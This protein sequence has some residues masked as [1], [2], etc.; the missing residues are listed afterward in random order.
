MNAEDKTG[1]DRF[2]IR[3]YGI[4]EWEQKIL[5]I[6]ERI[7]DFRFTKF[8]GGGLE[9]GEGLHDGL[10]REFMEEAG[11]GIKVQSHFYT[12]HFF[13]QSMFRTSDQLIAVYYRVD[14]LV[15]AE[16]I[17]LE[18]FCIE[19]HGKQE[20]LQF[21]WVEKENFSPELLTFPVDKHVASLL[22]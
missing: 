12:T 3:V 1:V 2:N 20:E 13:Q 9:F 17:P 21:F 7:G 10:I 18:Q 6:R 5:L 19:Q 14:P 16:Q 4:L 8:P 15:S 11:I 22:L